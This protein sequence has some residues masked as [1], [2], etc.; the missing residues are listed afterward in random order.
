MMADDQDAVA[1]LFA[2]IA[3]EQVVID[4][5]AAATERLVAIQRAK[6]ELASYADSLHRALALRHA[7][8]GAS[9]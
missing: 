6:R 2:T 3:C 5:I 8:L 4:E 1:E 7:A 9:A